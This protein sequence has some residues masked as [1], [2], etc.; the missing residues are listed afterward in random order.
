MNDEQFGLI[1]KPSNEPDSKIIY[2]DFD[3]ANAKLVVNIRVKSFDENDP[4]AYFGIIFR[5]LKDQ[6]TEEYYMLKILKDKAE[7]VKITNGNEDFINKALFN[8][9]LVD[10]NNLGI[11]RLEIQYLINKIDIK[12][13]ID[14]S[15]T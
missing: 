10:E 4:L 8:F 6:E 12:M 9:G 3:C 7:L 13:M 11:Y 2:K 14:P 5:Y 1:I 15:I